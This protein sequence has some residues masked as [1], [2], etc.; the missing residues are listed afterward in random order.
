MATSKHL[1]IRAALAAAI[2]AAGVLPAARVHENRD[3]T[4]A[5]GIDSQLH[6]NF[7]QSRPED[8]VVFSTQP[9]DWTSEYEI[10]ILARKAAG[11]EASSAADALWASV[12]QAVMAD[13][14]IGGR[15]IDLEP[16][17]A[18]VAEDEG[19]TSLCRLI[20]TLAV[21]HRTENNT[22]T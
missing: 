2:V 16:G 11:V 1:Q 18:S 21:Q 22:I 12:Y 20:W 10:V 19:D 3:F 9:R 17:E 5:T 14:S 6:V 4:L 7:R 15:A 8:V 13:R